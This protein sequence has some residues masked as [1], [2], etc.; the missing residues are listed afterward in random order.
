[1]RR[2]WH[3]SLVVYTEHFKLIIILE[4]F[5]EIVGSSRFLYI[6][7]HNICVIFYILK[8]S[9]M[10]IGGCVCVCGVGWGGVGWGA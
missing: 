7:Y 6:T 10:D 4:I 9:Y 5:T 8:R 2:C 3:F 1:M